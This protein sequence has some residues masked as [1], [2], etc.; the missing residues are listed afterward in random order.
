MTPDDELQLMTPTAAAVSLSFEQAVLGAVMHRPDLLDRMTWLQAS[1]FHHPVHRD[2]YATLLQMQEQRIPIDPVTTLA[3]LR[4]AGRLDLNPNERV[5]Y[6]HTLYA[7]V[8]LPESAVVYARG[9]LDAS[10]QRE[11]AAIGVR[12]RQVGL[13]S[14]DP[15]VT[16]HIAR[17]Q[18][19]RLDAADERLRTAQR[20]AQPRPVRTLDERQA[21]AAR[22]LVQALGWTPDEV[23]ADLHV[24][25]ESVM[26]AVGDE[27]DLDL[28]DSVAGD[29]HALAEWSELHSA[30]EP[31]LRVVDGDVAL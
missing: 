13:E 24:P 3:A 29:P 5:S 17:E 11:V 15:A 16:L 27:P 28:P 18:L 26:R 20:E 31:R 30:D 9:V 6:L 19:A 8:P 12:I 1:D 21:E 4:Q 10:I 14:D 23:A 7:G 22:V 2:L 25:V